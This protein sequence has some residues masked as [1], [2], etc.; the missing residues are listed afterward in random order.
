M[1]FV[2][3]GIAAMTGGLDTGSSTADSG[4]AATEDG[5]HAGVA[6]A[7]PVSVFGTT[8]DLVVGLAAMGSGSAEST[9]LLGTE[10]STSGVGAVGAT[11]G[12]AT[13]ATACFEIAGDF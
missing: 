9:C 1:G 3:L 13:E 10:A 8:G 11:G 6:G 12:L 2:T 5:I 7:D 4:T